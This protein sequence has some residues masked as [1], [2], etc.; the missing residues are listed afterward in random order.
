MKSKSSQ[1]SGGLG[2]HPYYAH[3]YQGCRE[4]DA[5]SRIRDALLK[6]ETLVVGE[7]G[8]DKAWIAKVLFNVRI[9]FVF[10]FVSYFLIFIRKRAKTSSLK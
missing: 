7:I 9:F 5:I 2:V 1:V 10:F 4:S 8:I 3:L 6:D